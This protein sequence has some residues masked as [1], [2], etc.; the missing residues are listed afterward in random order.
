MLRLSKLYTYHIDDN[1]LKVNLSSCTCCTR[2]TLYHSHTHTHTHTLTRSQERRECSVLSDPLLLRE[3]AEELKRDSRHGPRPDHPQL[4]EEEKEEE[5]GGETEGG[6]EER[7][8]F[9]AVL[10]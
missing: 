5:E 2:I 7:H 9:Q 6:K 10:K 1:G 3:V 4:E 8:S